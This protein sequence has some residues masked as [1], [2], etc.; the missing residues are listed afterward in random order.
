[1]HITKVE[2]FIIRIPVRHAIV[3]TAHEFLQ[4]TLRKDSLQRWWMA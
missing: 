4:T 1:M 2:T 3:G